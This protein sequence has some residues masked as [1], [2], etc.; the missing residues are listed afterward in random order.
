MTMPV[1]LRQAQDDKVIYQ[2][3]K[4]VVMVPPSVMMFPIVM[5]SLSN[6]A[7][8]DALRMTRLF[9]RVT[10]ESVMVP[11]SVMMFPVVMVSQL[12]W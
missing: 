11:P 10:K 5:V 6:H 8:F 2:G 1:T 3:D 9:I 12:S 7:P 4:R